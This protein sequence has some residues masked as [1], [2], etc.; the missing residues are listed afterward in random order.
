MV[1]A[2]V[3]MA[4][5]VPQLPNHRD[6]GGGGVIIGAYARMASAPPQERRFSTS[7]FYNDMN[8]TTVSD[9]YVHPVTRD[10]YLCSPSMN[11][12]VRITSGG[13]RSA[14]SAVMAGMRN[15]SGSDDGG[16]GEVA[17]FDYPFGITG[18]GG[19]M[20]YIG[21]TRNNKIRSVNISMVRRELVAVSTVAGNGTAGFV[22][23]I[24]GTVTFNNP[25]GVALNSIGT[26]LYIADYNNNAVRKVNL[27]TR[28]VTTVVASE[29]FLNEIFFIAVNSDERF[30]YATAPGGHCVA[31]VDLLAKNLDF[32]VTASTA[33]Q[34]FLLDDPYGT[35]PVGIYQPIGLLLTP[36]ESML[37]VS[38]NIHA[39]RAVKLHNGTHI[40]NPIITIAGNGSSGYVDASLPDT[41][42]TS[43]FM[44]EL[45]TSMFD[46]PAGMVWWNTLNTTE[47]STK[48]LHWTFLVADHQNNAIRA[49]TLLNDAF[50]PFPPPQLESSSQVTQVNSA[51]QLSSLY[52]HLR[53]DVAYAVNM[54]TEI[55]AVDDLERGGTG[56][57][58]VANSFSSISC[59]TGDDGDFLYVVDNATAL[60]RVSLVSINAVESIASFEFVVT[61][62]VVADP[63]QPWSTSTS[64]CKL[65]VAGGDSIVVI[66]MCEENAIKSLA[67]TTL[68]T[69]SMYLM[70]P[71]VVLGEV[72]S[73]FVASSS[74]IQCLD[75]LTPNDSVIRSRVVVGSV[76]GTSTNANGFGT[77]ASFPNSVI[78]ITGS[79]TSDGWPCLF[80]TSS[81][82]V[83]RPSTRVLSLF[84]IRLYDQYM[85]TVTTSRSITLPTAAG[86]R[87]AGDTP[88]KGL[89]YYCNA[90]TGAFG[91]LTVVQPM[92]M[93][94]DPVGDSG[95]FFL[96]LGSSKE[97]C[98]NGATFT[99]SPLALSRSLSTPCPQLLVVKVRNHNCTPANL[100]TDGINAS[101]TS[102]QKCTAITRSDTSHNTTGGPFDTAVLI[103]PLPHSMR[104]GTALVALGFD[105]SDGWVLRSTTNMTSISV[106]LPA[107]P[108]PPGILV[109]GNITHIMNPPPAYDSITIIKLLGTCAIGGLEVN[110]SIVVHWPPQPASPQPTT[111]AV[112]NSDATV[113]L[114]SSASIL[115]LLSGGGAAS[116]VSVVMLSLLQCSSHPPISTAT[117]FVS[118]FFELGNA[119]MATGNVGVCGG[120]FCLQLMTIW[121]LRRWNGN[122]QHETALED[123]EINAAVLEHRGEAPKLSSQ[124]DVI[125]KYLQEMALMRL[126]AI[127]VV[128]GSMLLPGA[129]LGAVAGFVSENS[130]SSDLVVCSF[131]FFFVII[132]ICG[133]VDVIRRTVLL[134][135][136]FVPYRVYSVGTEMEKRFLFP[137]GRWEPANIRQAFGPLMNPMRKEYPLLLVAELLL[138]CF[139]GLVS[140]VFIGGACAAWL[141]AAASAMYFLYGVALVVLRPHRLPFDRFCAPAV[142]LLLGVLCALQYTEDDNSGDTRQAIQL[143]VSA[144]QLLR[145]ASGMFIVYVR[146]SDLRAGDETAPAHSDDTK[147]MSD[148]MHAE[149]PIDAPL[150]LSLTSEIDT[151]ID[152]RHTEAGGDCHNPPPLLVVA[153]EV[154]DDVHQKMFWDDQGRAVVKLDK[155]NADGADQTPFMND[156]QCFFGE[157]H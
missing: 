122:K 123:S 135:A 16:F 77:N 20:L 86:G 46:R 155:V 50:D 83:G 114:L 74:T 95:I 111:A 118:V 81:N 71:A 90:S 57:R 29:I 18:D 72:V 58:L 75:V 102:P 106:S 4:T 32:N 94:R 105:I 34:P 117:Y 148:V 150:L 35:N 44:A 37:L 7:T 131:A 5:S 98:P 13:T 28:A 53:S 136:S 64:S 2:V 66:N 68:P 146:E 149:D 70:A 42:V 100:E 17:T 23:G 73:L 152:L 110:I 99:A 119:A 151:S 125:H 21:D 8:T 33:G 84:E 12:I 132:M 25:T 87:D 91:L 69:V 63:V 54:S 107:Y 47:L 39:I 145:S 120:V 138:S 113:G 52:V 142:N 92:T 51:P 38:D 61:A 115:T 56:F 15:V 10:V 67:S 27:S 48:R 108:T 157:A 65:F 31:R 30:L 109:S 144:L 127:G 9:L 85:R 26:T 1:V 45:S 36:D 124:A 143:I 80:A 3:L 79:G 121:C 97:K 89:S 128:V 147:E 62:M 134:R 133:E 140:G 103:T 19:D 11:I 153:T 24:G 78:D 96:S 6:S 156:L 101:D 59:M 22:D 40:A 82:T 41:G 126:P 14:S 141:L 116:S 60:H 49:V 137:E 154:N 55:I 129:V 43:S 139:V 76:S 104:D 112:T 93:G 88:R 130:S